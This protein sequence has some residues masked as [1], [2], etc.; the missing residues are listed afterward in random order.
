[1]SGDGF[2]GV[3]SI[4]LRRKERD[5]RNAITADDRNRGGL[6]RPCQRLQAPVAGP[7]RPRRRRPGSAT[8]A[9]PRGRASEATGPISSQSGPDDHDLDALAPLSRKPLQPR[10][11]SPGPPARRRRDPPPL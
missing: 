8:P 4:P 6:R 11:A 5:R 1:V 2:Q 3:S 7:P 10:A 9:A